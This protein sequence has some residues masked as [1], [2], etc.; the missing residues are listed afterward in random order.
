M[1][2]RLLRLSLLLIIFGATLFALAPRAHAGEPVFIPGTSVGLIPPEGMIPAGD[3]LGFENQRAGAAITLYDLPAESY[4]PLEQDFAASPPDELQLEEIEREEVEIP[5]VA[6][7]LLITGKTRA[8]TVSLERWIL[9]A[10]NEER[11]ALVIGEML[12]DNGVYEAQAMREAVLSLVFRERPSLAERNALL[13]F[14]VGDLAGLESLEPPA[15]A[16]MLLG[17]EGAQEA[18]EEGDLG[19]PLVVVA[20]I[21]EEQPPRQVHDEL[22]REALYAVPQLSIQRIESAEGF[23]QRNDDWHEIVARAR[24]PGGEELVVVQ[25]LRFTRQGVLRMF[26]SVRA[27]E[28]EEMLPRFRRIIDSA[29]IRAEIR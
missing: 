25:T 6:R 3:F 10:T 29:E 5:G 17:R 16:V 21:T 8:E 9:I 4:D 24:A 14:T 7:A 27:E 1:T 11:A 15:D 2:A 20:L 12:A 13:P 22:A 19:Q 23:R 28:R 26:A 18:L